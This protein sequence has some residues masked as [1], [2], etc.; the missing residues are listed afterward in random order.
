MSDSSRPMGPVG[1]REVEVVSSRSAGLALVLT[2]VAEVLWTR[3]ALGL[4][5]LAIML[6]SAYVLLS[7]GARISVCL[8]GAN[9]RIALHLLQAFTALCVLYVVKVDVLH[10]SALLL[11]A[12][13]LQL[14]R[15][16]AAATRVANR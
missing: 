1:F 5:D 7:P 15:A 8:Q 6:V 10:S 12:A 2:V 16:Q 3:R 4:P 13:V 14:A 9:R 11:G